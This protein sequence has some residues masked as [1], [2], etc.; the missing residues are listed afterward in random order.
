MDDRYKVAHKLELATAELNYCLRV[1]GDELANRN[2]YKIHRGLDA[3]HFHL[4]QKYNWSPSVVRAMS[5]DDLRF[6]L[7]EEM[8]GWALPKAAQ[9]EA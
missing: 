6:C 7:E 5:M 9:P 2:K 3:V 4:V 8:H 1:Y